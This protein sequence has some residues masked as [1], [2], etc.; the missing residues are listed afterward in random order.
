M[1]MTRRKFYYEKNMGSNGNSSCSIRND[2]YMMWKQQYY[3]RYRYNTG[4]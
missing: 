1:V 3:N 4:V 2:L